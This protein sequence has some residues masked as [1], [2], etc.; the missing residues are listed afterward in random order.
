M[1]ILQVCTNV[2]TYPICTKVYQCKEKLA[3][4]MLNFFQGMKV[5]DEKNIGIQSWRKSKFALG[6]KNHQKSEKVHKNNKYY[7][8]GF[9]FCM[10]MS[11]KLENLNL[12]FNLS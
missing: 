8:R 5:K 7:N 2:L 3:G 1:H 6:K 4:D 9:K 10:D 12:V 11:F